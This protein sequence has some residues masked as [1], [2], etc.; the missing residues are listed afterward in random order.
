MRKVIEFDDETW[1]ALVQLGRDRMATLQELADESFADLLK[2]H[3]VPKDLKDALRRSAKA[4]RKSGKP[5][6]RTR[7]R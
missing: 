3:G 2:K 7:R 6:S 1:R 4:A 5:A